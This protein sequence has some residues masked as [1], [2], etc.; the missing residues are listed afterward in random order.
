MADGKLYHRSCYKRSSRPERPSSALVSSQQAPSAPS[1]PL[2]PVSLVSNGLKKPST[3]LPSTPSTPPD[4]RPEWQRKLLE[5]S[6]NRRNIVGATNRASA[7][8]PVNENSSSVKGGLSGA[9]TKLPKT[10][11]ERVQLRSK[12]VDS[13]K[14]NP[15]PRA[16]SVGVDL[17]ERISKLRQL[18][19][20]A[21]AS[22][23]NPAVRAKL[24]KLR[25]R[26]LA[27]SSKLASTDS[28]DN[29]SKSGTNSTN[30]TS[31]NSTANATSETIS[32]T[33]TESDSASITRVTS[34][35]E[36]SSQSTASE[37]QEEAEEVGVQD[38]EVGESPTK[39]EKEARHADSS[40][41]NDSVIES[42]TSAQLSSQNTD[43]DVTS[44]DVK[45]P[46]S[47]SVSISVTG[48]I[49][50]ESAVLEADS[51]LVSD[52]SLERQTAGEPKAS[53]ESAAAKVDR[54]PS[55]PA[56]KH[57]TNPFE[58]DDEE[59]SQPALSQAAGRL[60]N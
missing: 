17:D 44:E 26:T 27:G 25:E 58:D 39:S 57:S 21:K 15:L 42:S 13:L 36:S 38:V 29:T 50:Q 9:A 28:T 7:L 14:K 4:P 49:H 47:S 1:T 33:T 19:E 46:H 31:M 52:I 59:E 6:A 30:S 11:A 22:G 8:D 20:S 51:N 16:V 18:R 34:S 10:E 40:N 45:Q 2:R 32:S 53:L 3:S 12:P 56:S 55:V 5:K 23:G 37:N 35:T 41:S 60:S 24:E 48:S 43:N 54:T